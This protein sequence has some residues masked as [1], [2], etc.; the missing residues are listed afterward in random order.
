MKKLFIVALPVEIGTE[1]IK[2]NGFKAITAEDV[3]PA[4]YARGDDDYVAVVGMGAKDSA[5][6]MK[7]L[8]KMG[9]L[10]GSHV[11]LS[12]SAGSYALPVLSVVQ[13]ASGFRELPL[14]ECKA[15]L[16]CVHEFVSPEHPHPE[17]Q[18]PS[19]CFDMES[20]F[21]AA[22]LKDA[23]PLTFTIVKTI[24]DDGKGS[25]GDWRTV[26]EQHV[27]PIVRQAAARF[28]AYREE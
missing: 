25:L 27:Q 26:C 24:S 15:T 7:V 18:A 20:E 4:V 22:G 6:S 3:F 2:E 13:C 19:T 1:V 9:L 28:F 12:G 23:E 14:A 5:A 10:R 8:D 21:I 17:L 16:V 11:V